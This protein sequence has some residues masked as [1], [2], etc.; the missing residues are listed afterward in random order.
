MVAIIIK[1]PR[2]EMPEWV[3]KAWLM[4]RLEFFPVIGNRSQGILSGNVQESVQPLFY[5][6]EETAINELRKMNPAAADYWQSLGFPQ[7]GR[8]FVFRED[9]LQPVGDSGFGWG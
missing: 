5:T 3:R 2:G 7:A 8:V 6:D 9:E 1:V 4:I